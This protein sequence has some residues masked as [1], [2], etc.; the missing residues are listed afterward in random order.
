MK[1]IKTKRRGIIYVRVSSSDQIDGTSLDDQQQRCIKY[2]DEQGIEVVQIFREEGVSAKSADR[3][4]LLE[5]I[6]FC[7]KNKSG[8]GVQAFVVYKVDRFAR[9]TEDHFAVKKILIGHGTSL[10]SVSEPIGN[11]PTEKLMETMLAG[12]AEFDNEIRKQRCTGGMLAR[13]KQGIWPWKPP[14]GYVCSQHKKNGEKKTLPD[15]PD[16][17]VFPL[18]QEC[19]KGFCKEVY[20][21]TDIIARLEKANFKELTGIKPS[22]NLVDR[23]TGKYLSFLAGLLPTPWP[24]QEDGSDRYLSGGHKAIITQD[25]MLQIRL[26]RSGRHPNK[27]VRDRYN[28]NFPLRRLVRCP[29]CNDYYTGSTS[30]GRNAKYQYYHCQTETCPNKNHSI[31]KQEI[32]DDFEVLLERIK[33]IPEF[34]KYFREVTL[35]HWTNRRDFLVDT[36]KKYEKTID[37]L[38]GQRRNICLMRERGESD[39]ELFKER[40]GEVDTAIAVNK[41][42]LAESNIDT[43]DIE[44]GISYAEQFVSDIKRQWLDLTPQ[45]RPP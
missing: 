28:P 15:K 21:A 9:N 25:E 6:E 3:K 38:K 42:S 4:K 22:H 11:N 39:A 30:T 24:E 1:T 36:A 27:V 5:A 40:L 41:I 17:R 35:D 12:F 31:R 37:D 34:L 33:L 43:F 16:M 26:I 44:A 23:L 10:M 29:S 13:L 7:R 45:L 32:E 8:G 18:I 19:L 14:V 2:C 20:T